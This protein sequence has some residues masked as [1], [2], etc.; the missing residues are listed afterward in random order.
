M[1]LEGA[2]KRT[3]E[4]AQGALDGLMRRAGALFDNDRLEAYRPRF[5]GAVNIVWPG[6][7]G[8]IRIGQVGL[9]ASDSLT[10]VAQRFF[11]DR[12]QVVGHGLSPIDVG[13]RVQQN[14][15]RSVELLLWMGVGHFA[16]GQRAPLW[17]FCPL[18]LCRPATSLSSA[19][20]R[21]RF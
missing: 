11:H 21:A 5:Q 20:S 8:A 4:L 15:H 3:L 6:L 16:I 18:F 12:L 9:D 17:S 1:L 14:L 7:S 2:G 10:I 13:I 19:F